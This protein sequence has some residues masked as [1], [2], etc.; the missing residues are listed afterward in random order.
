MQLA[1]LGKSRCRQDCTAF[2]GCREFISCVFQLLVAA[3]CWHFLTRGHLTLV[4]GSVVTLLP[5]ILFMGAPQVALVVKMSPANAGDRERER[6]AI[7]PWV[8]K[9]PW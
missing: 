2:Q 5:P 9:I 1:S 7:D 6:C 3:G 8:G 4:S